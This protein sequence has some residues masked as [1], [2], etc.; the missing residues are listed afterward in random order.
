MELQLWFFAAKRAPDLSNEENLY[1]AGANYGEI[2]RGQQMVI[3]E[4][5]TQQ[6]VDIRVTDSVDRDAL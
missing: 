2:P 1:A 3:C 4:L 5:P 6:K